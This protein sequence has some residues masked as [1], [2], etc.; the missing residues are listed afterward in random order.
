MAWWRTTMNTSNPSPAHPA[1]HDRRRRSGHRFLRH[2]SQSLVRARRIGA[3]GLFTEG[4]ARPARC[5][6]LGPRRGPILG[7]EDLRAAD[8][9]IRRFCQARI[10]KPFA[11]FQGE[12][13]LAVRMQRIYQHV[14]LVR[15]DDRRNSPAARR[16]PIGSRSCRTECWRDR[17][18]RH[19]IRPGHYR[20]SPSGL[21]HTEAG[22]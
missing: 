10:V 20:S 15:H 9:W 14:V 17:M 11:D 3:C 12:N 19:P 8:A 16:P 7:T 1:Q 18:D 5:D 21:G 6:A 2:Q 4:H 22:S 13:L